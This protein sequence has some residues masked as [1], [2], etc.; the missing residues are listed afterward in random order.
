MAAPHID[1]PFG[2]KPGTGGEPSGT[3]ISKQGGPSTANITKNQGG[4]KDGNKDKNAKDNKGL[5]VPASDGPRCAHPY[6]NDPSDPSDYPIGLP[7]ASGLLRCLPGYCKKH[8]KEAV[9]NLL[10]QGE[11][12]LGEEEE[13]SDGKKRDKKVCKCTEDTA[14]VC[15]HKPDDKPPY[16]EYIYA[17]DPTVGAELCFF[18]RMMMVGDEMDRWDEEERKAEREAAKKKKEK[19]DKKMKNKKTE[20]SDKGKGGNKGSKGKKVKVQGKADG[21]KQTGGSNPKISKDKSKTSQKSNDAAPAQGGDDAAAQG[22][23]DAVEQEIEPA[24]EE[25]LEN[26]EGVNPNP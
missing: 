19:K 16:K 17:D 21:G 3:D 24:I 25:P 7:W 15:T 10:D 11:E 23:Q 4:N 14:I 26:D 1:N 22:G 18:L 9:D 12:D 13:G 5:I 8:K 20:T 6:C 2:A